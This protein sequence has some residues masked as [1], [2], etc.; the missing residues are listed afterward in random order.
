[1]QHTLQSSLRQC[2]SVGL[3]CL[4]AMAVGQPQTLDIERARELDLDSLRG[5]GPTTT[6]QILQERDRQAFRDWKDLMQRVSGIG[7]KKAADLSDQGLRVAN[8]SFPA[9]PAR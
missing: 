9:R 2:L 8:E 4:S 6:R 1:M 7:P 3:L 5:L